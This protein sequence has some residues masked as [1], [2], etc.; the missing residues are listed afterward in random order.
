MRHDILSNIIINKTNFSATIYNKKNAHGTNIN[1]TCWAIIIK[2]EG[3]TC[4]T[5][6]SGVY[7]SNIN[8]VVILP[9]GC[10]YSW[11][12][13]KEGHFSVIEFESNSTFDDIIYFPNIDGEK[14]LR[15]F[16][17]FEHRHALKK[18]IYEIENINEIYSLIIELLKSQKQKYIPSEKYNKILPAIEHITK[19]YTQ[20]I[21]CEELSKICGISNIYFRKLFKETMNCT[22]IEYLQR[23]K[24]QK[25]KEMLK[26]D[27][28]TLSDIAYSLGYLNIHD[29]SRAFKNHVG[30]PPS[31]Y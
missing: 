26:S 4:Y 7:I 10:N 8:N 5:T 23:L 20:K 15:H 18:I 9:K 17:N 21:K 6:K 19:N 3:E 27:Y 1:R 2:Y 25:A 12:C 31:K 30:V 24:I 11:Q 14:I 16:K 28:G 13:T 22:P 29:F